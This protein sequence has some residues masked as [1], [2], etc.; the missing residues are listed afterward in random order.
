MK[1]KM[2][3]YITI[4]CT[5]IVF[6]SFSQGIDLTGTVYYSDYRSYKI[7]NPNAIVN[8][9]MMDY[10]IR[11]YRIIDSLIFMSEKTCIYKQVF[12]CDSISHS[13][14]DFNIF[15]NY[16]LIDNMLYLHNIHP[17]DTLDNKS[18]ILIPV[19]TINNSCFVQNKI[20][21]RETYGMKHFY[22]T[23][24]D[25]SIASKPYFRYFENNNLVFRDSLLFY[26]YITN[27]QDSIEVVGN[28]QFLKN[29]Y[30]NIQ[31]S[32]SEI[33][34]HFINTDKFNF[35]NYIDD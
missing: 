31:M 26:P 11:D 27:L 18:Y 12:I 29:G 10:L 4:L 35:M 15:C 2:I 9:S 23:L 28:I 32:N 17:I 19:E 1:K 34:N 25:E 30:K 16:E 7:Y 3:V 21:Y 20:E 24:E 13:Y 5:C 6:L 14:M 22:K 33:F 8:D